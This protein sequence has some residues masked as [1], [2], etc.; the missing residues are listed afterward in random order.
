[1]QY[2]LTFTAMCALS[3]ALAWAGVM[4]VGPI[5]AVIGLIVFPIAVAVQRAGGSRARA[6]ALVAGITAAA[7]LGAQNVVGAGFYG[8]AA[9]LGLLLGH[10]IERGW[11]YGRC[12]AAVTAGAYLFVAG[13]VIV[14]WDESRTYAVQLLDDQIA[15]LRYTAGVAGNPEAAPDEQKVEEALVSPETAPI[16]AAPP[17]QDAKAPG[18]S[19]TIAALR[20]MQAHWDETNVG[21]ALWPVLFGALFVVGF[22]GRWLRLKLRRPGPRGSFREMRPPDALVWLAIAAA[23]AVFADRQWPN[24]WLR[25]G[26]W[27]AAIGLAAVYWVNGLSVVT[28]AVVAVRPHPMFAVFALAVLLFLP[29][30]HASVCGVGFFDTWAEFRPRLERVLEARRNREMNDDHKL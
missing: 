17:N 1:M 25:T 16:A 24:D 28:Y 2:L 20:W 14:T 23:L 30:V 15:Q 7:W 10:G 13:A 6:L 18:L 22:T 19:E 26:A 11:S 9:L 5:V 21:L 12:V 27:N 29:G 8:L 4:G 3:F